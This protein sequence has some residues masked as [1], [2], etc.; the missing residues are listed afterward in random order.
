MACEAARRSGL[1]WSET[2]LLAL[3]L[4]A[5]LTALTAE[6]MMG[7]LYPALAAHYGVT[8]DRV[9]LLTT[10]RALAQ[11]GVV[12]LGPLS[13]RLGR[14]PIVVGGL[15]LVAAGAW[16]GALA[17]DLRAMA[18]VQVALGLGL[19]IAIAHIPAL[20]GDRYPYAVRG[21]VLA[22]V[23]LGMP[24]SLMVVVPAMLGLALRRGV[25]GPFLALGAAATALTLLAAWRLPAA[26]GCPSRADAGPPLPLATWAGPRVVGMLGLSLVFAA[27]PTAI[28]GFLTGW[29]GGT[30]AD[31]GRTVRLAVACDG[32]GTLVGVVG[33]ALIVDRLTKRRASVLG[34]GLGG[35]F[36]WLLPATGGIF[37]LAAMAVVGLAAS[38]E[39]C[40]VALSALLSE[41]APQARGTLL[42]LWAAALAAGAALAPPLAGALWR[43]GGMA[44]IGRTGG[45][46]LLLLAAILSWMAREPGQPAK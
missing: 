29:V 38:L 30:F 44:A 18:A 42:S 9:V 36:A 4:A 21:R 7:A 8:L 39:L 37:A 5:N 14:A 26:V 45:V 6:T 13:E 41:L 16:G 32:L 28:F 24:A 17:P 3:L 46:L 31:P 43:H 33:S 11:L 23:R 2:G 40:F 20:V 35:V 1:A 10:P 22:V 19:A 27:V 12:F 15:L 25:V 34:L